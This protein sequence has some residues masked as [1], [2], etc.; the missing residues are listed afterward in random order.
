MSM[1]KG[2]CGTEGRGFRRAGRLTQSSRPLGTPAFRS[3]KPPAALSSP[4]ACR[5]PAPAPPAGDGALLQHLLS[6]GGD[7]VQGLLSAFGAAGERIAQLASHFGGAVADRAQAAHEAY[8]EHGERLASLLASGADRLM[9]ALA[10]GADRRQELVGGLAAKADQRGEAFQ[11]VRGPCWGLLHPCLSRSFF[12][13]S[14]FPFLLG[15]GGVRWGGWKL[16]PCPGVKQPIVPT[17]KPLTPPR[18]VRPPPHA[19]PP[20]PLHRHTPAPPPPLPA[21]SS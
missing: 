18:I 5:R 12:A 8:S 11:Q 17:T 10:A 6:S 9:G 3:I 1:C 14:F 16:M 19:Q 7:K 15:F 21:R 4:P 20:P 13:L 2:A